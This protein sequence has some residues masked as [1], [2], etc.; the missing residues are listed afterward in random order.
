ML[1]PTMRWARLLATS[2]VLAVPTDAAAVGD[3]GTAVIDRPSGFGAL[4]FDG[5]SDSH[6]GPRTISANGCFIVF[7]SENDALFAGDENGAANIYRKDRC[8]PGHP[9]VQVN[10]SSAGA[11]PEPGREATVP[12]ISANGR[13]VAFISDAPSLSPDANGAP[14]VWVKDMQ[15]GGVELASR[16]EG[17]QKLGQPGEPVISGDGNRVA[18]A[19]DGFVDA[20]N[21]DGQAGQTNVY[22]RDLATDHTYPA[23]IKSS[24]GKAG[25]GATGD[26]DISFDGSAVAFTGQAQL[27]PTD[28]DFDADAYLA[29]SIGP[30]PTQTLV[31][32]TVGNTSGAQTAYDIT[33]G[34]DGATVAWANGSHPWLTTCTPGCAT[35]AN[36]DFGVDPPVTD[37]QVFGIGFGHSTSGGATAPARVYW[38]TTAPLVAGDT[39]GV[40]D[41][42][43]HSVSDLTVGGLSL[44]TSGTDPAGVSEAR[45]SDDGALLAYRNN[46]P[47]LPGSNGECC[48]V[49]LREAGGT[50]NLSQP[51]GQPLHT[52]EAGDAQLNNGHVLST[53]GR[54]A[55]FASTAAG[56][57]SPYLD[58]DE[59]RDQ[60][61]RRDM[62]TGETLPVSVDGAGQFGNDFSYV[63]SVDAAGSRVAFVSMATNLVAGAT[64]SPSGHVYVRDLPTGTTKLL[65]RAATGDPSTNGVQLAKISGGGRT[66]VF[67][68]DS[69][70]LPG[71]PASGR[72]AYAADVDSGAITLVDK[73][74]GGTAANGNVGAADIAAIGERIIFQTDANNLGGAAKPSVYLKDL[75]NGAVTWIGKPEDNDP[76]H[77]GA[78]P[79][80]AISGD[81]QRVAFVETDS[82]FGFGA[83][84]VPH[85]FLRDL[86]ARTTAIV[87]LGTEL[88]TNAQQGGPSLSGDGRRLTFWEDAHPG[89]PERVYYRD[90]VAGTTT[91]LESTRDGSDVAS[92]DSTGTCAAFVSFGK[93]IAAD[94]YPGTDFKHAYVRAFRGDCPPV[95]PPGGGPG[96][97]STSDTTAPVISGARVTN[98]RFRVAAKRTALTAKR[99]KRGTTFVFSLSEPARTT[100]AIAQRLPG[101]KKGTKCVKPRKRLKK[102][103]TRYVAKLTLTRT[104][105]A[106]GP[107]RVAY[108]GRTAKGRLKPGR[109]RATLHATDAAGHRSQARTVTFR[110]VRR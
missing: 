4:P 84:G 16:D 70:D 31:S 42:Y 58:N 102:R 14:M 11:Q 25:G 72:H 99:A 95:P 41:I 34:S 1:A 76:A 86:A 82:Q 68:S 64:Q 108:S 109:Y 65:D 81:G 101:R 50:A 63:A 7:E 90:L 51:E 52:E 83:N 3:G 32:Y 80:L 13:H 91:P 21:T 88:G 78:R 43:S 89:S 36:L 110:V 20:A 5:I 17:G 66:V 69:P 92:L 61:F 29:R 107:N 60:I 22:V 105:S 94:G 45:G 38:A 48:Q 73:T 18:F 62:L 59:H 75:T 96:P 54:F 77:T 87:S 67:V 9:L 40:T 6:I 55:V 100:I 39:D 46:S 74:S 26:V 24:D 33:I 2:F 30:S 19:L 85:V 79:E 57:G 98:R 93:G 104:K 49:F 8:S 97:G 35:A 10:V 28:I 15:T 106:Q 12:S 56:L 37:Q 53:N 71:A 23:S 44:V 103:C 47:L 27:T